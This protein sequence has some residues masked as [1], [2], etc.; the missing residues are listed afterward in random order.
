VGE[1]LVESSEASGRLAS[2]LNAGAGSSQGVTFHDFNGV[3]LLP[4]PEITQKLG[5]GWTRENFGM[6]DLEP[7]KDKWNWGKLDSRVQQAHAQGVEVLPML[8]GVGWA[9][10]EHVED[11][12]NFVDHVVAHYSAPPFSLRCFQVWNEPTTQAG[13][14][15]GKTNLDFV[16]LVYLPAAR[17]I[18]RHNCLVVFGGWPLSNNLQEFSQILSYHDAWRWTDI[19]D[20]H[21]HGNLAWQPLY[22]QWVR[23]GRCRGIWQTEVGFTSF[24]IGVPNLY[25][26]SLYWAL[27]AGWKDPVQY[28]VFWYASWGAGRDGDKC[29]VKPGPDN[30]NVLTQN[31]QQ[32]AVMSDVFGGGSLAIFSQFS[33]NPTLPAALADYAPAALGFKV[34]E[35]RIAI[36]LILDKAT[37][38]NRDALPI[39]V[40]LKAGPR[41]IELVTGS[42][43]RR[44]LQG[45]YNRG[46]LQVSVPLQVLANDSLAGKNFVGYVQ[47]ELG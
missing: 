2:R 44:T 23:T 13:F 45:T 24:P 41:Q 1:T 11:W 30:K 26:R 47:I 36:A 42:G 12:E 16:D 4:A 31:G 22:Q 8:A 9:A 10:P 46:V 37:Y 35:S 19:L 25:L 34:G 27:Q 18:R 40:S 39:T 14:W 7:Q 5:I 38:G 28:K 21:Y 3:N 29:L 6:P 33:T 15:K 20:V 32:L 17:I 43:Q